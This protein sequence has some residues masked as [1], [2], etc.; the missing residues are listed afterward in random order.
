MLH[1]NSDPVLL[2]AGCIPGMTRDETISEVER[3]E[4]K[5][6]QR[7]R[8]RCPHCGVQMDYDWDWDTYAGKSSGWVC[9]DCDVQFFTDAIEDP[10]HLLFVEENPW[11]KDESKYLFIGHNGK[12]YQ[13]HKNE[14]DRSEEEQQELLK[15][16]S[17]IGLTLADIEA[18]EQSSSDISSRVATYAAAQ[19]LRRAAQD[20]V[21]EKFGQ[22]Y[23]LPDSEAEVAKFRRIEHIDGEVNFT[24]VV[25]PTFEME[26]VTAF[27]VDPDASEEE[28]NER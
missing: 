13:F 10:H 5:E 9:D 20:L 14:A 22:V 15:L 17:T 2:N 6:D 25:A 1:I 3:R 27:K 23:N 16:L 11:Y 26:G 7:F 8:A 28:T 12:G 24:D 18:R 21:F 4:R 19:T